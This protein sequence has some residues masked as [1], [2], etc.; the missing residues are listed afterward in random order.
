MLHVSFF[1]LFKAI[2]LNPPTALH[3]DLFQDC[4]S[5]L[6]WLTMLI[7]QPFRKKFFVFLTGSKHM[8]V[9]ILYYSSGKVMSSICNFFLSNYPLLNDIIQ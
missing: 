2:Q 1:F 9:Y 7:S 3:V 6:I 4:D 5:G 8:T